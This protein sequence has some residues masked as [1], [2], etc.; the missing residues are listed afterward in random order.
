MLTIDVIMD[1]LGDQ[2]MRKII[3]SYYENSG[4]HE[5]VRKAVS[6]AQEKELHIFNE[7]KE[8][9][10]RYKSRLQQLWQHLKQQIR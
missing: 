9:A 1:M 6:E 8:H 7:G 10:N 2:R 3:Y 4:E 5:L